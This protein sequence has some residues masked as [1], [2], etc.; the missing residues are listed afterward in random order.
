VRTRRW[1]QSSDAVAGASAALGADFYTPGAAAVEQA[2]ERR[3]SF[4]LIHLRTMFKIDIFPAGSRAFDRRQLARR[5]GQP[6]D[7]RPDEKLWILSAEDTI[8]AKLDW[9]RR[10]GEVSERQWRDVL[11]VMKAQSSGL[12]VAYLRQMAGEL[13]VEDLLARA[14]EEPEQDTPFA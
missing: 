1:N 5:I 4:N 3:S 13:R 11:G 6:I 14:L 2:I 9:F 12:D 8:L 10:G 7:S